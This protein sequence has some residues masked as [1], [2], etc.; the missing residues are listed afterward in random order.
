MIPAADC[1][2][3]GMLH[4]EPDSSAAGW[5]TLRRKPADEDAMTSVTLS[6]LK[7]PKSFIRIPPPVEI[8]KAFRRFFR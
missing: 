6:N 7:P 8:A 4:R 1:L 5:S 2:R 3:Q